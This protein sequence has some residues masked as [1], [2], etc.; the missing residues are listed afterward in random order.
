MAKKKDKYIVIKKKDLKKLQEDNE[1]HGYTRYDDGGRVDIKDEELQADINA[2]SR[3]MRLLEHN[4][5]Y[6]VINTNQPYAE[7]MWQILLAFEEL[8][9]DEHDE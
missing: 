1:I 9:G 6:L 7:P 3:I 5:E 4:N 2:F 8:R